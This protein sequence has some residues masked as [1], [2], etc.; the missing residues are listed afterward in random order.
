M[1]PRI[2]RLLKKGGYLAGKKNGKPVKLTHSKDGGIAVGAKH[3]LEG[4]IKGIVGTEKKPIEF[5]GEEIIITAPAVK[6]D[7][8]REFE[9]E[10]LTNRQIL[11]RI[12]ESGGGVSFADGGEIPK[13]IRCSGRTYNYGGETKTDYEIITSSCGCKHSLRK[14]GQ[15]FQYFD[16]QYDIDKA[17]KMIKSGRYIFDVK[18][19]PVYNV[20][21]PLFNKKYSDNL[22]PD[23]EVAQGLMIKLPGGQDFL[24]DGNHRMA[25]AHAKGMKKMKVYYIS[26]PQTIKEFSK[27]TLADGGPTSFS[28][29]VSAIAKNLKGQPVPAQYRKEYG[30]TYTVATA[31]EAATKIAGAMVRD[32]KFAEGGQAKVFT[33]TDQNKASIEKAFLRISKANNY[34]GVYE[35]TDEDGL[36]MEWGKYGY[37]ASESQQGEDYS[38]LLKARK[39]FNEEYDGS[40]VAFAEHSDKY[41]QIHILDYRQISN[42]EN[43]YEDVGRNKPEVL[44][45]INAAGFFNKKIDQKIAI[46]TKKKKAIQ[47]VIKKI[48]KEYGVQITE[49]EVQYFK[50]FEDRHKGMF[51]SEFKLRFKDQPFSEEKKFEN[52]EQLCN[53]LKSDKFIREFKDNGRQIADCTVWCDTNNFEIKWYKNEGVALL[54]FGPFSTANVNHSNFNEKYMELLNKFQVAYNEL[55]VNKAIE[56]FAEGGNVLGD[57]Y[58]K[59]LRDFKDIDSST[60]HI[61]PIYKDRPDELIKFVQEQ[62]TGLDTAKN[63]VHYPSAYQ[64]TVKLVGADLVHR[65]V[66]LMKPAEKNMLVKAWK[67]RIVPKQ[68]RNA[69]KQTMAE[70]GQVDD[71]NVLSVIFRNDFDFEVAKDF[72][73]SEKS[74]FQPFY[75]N[76]EFRS[77]DFQVKGQQDADTTEAALS[78]EL[79]NASITRYRFESFHEDN[80]KKGGFVPSHI[81]DRRDRSEYQRINNALNE[82]S[83]RESFF[84]ENAINYSPEERQRKFKWF[85]DERKKLFDQLD[86]ITGKHATKMADGG[87]INRNEIKADLALGGSLEHRHRDYKLLKA[88]VDYPEQNRDETEIRF[89]TGGTVKRYPDFSNELPTVINEQG[90]LFATEELTTPAVKNARQTWPQKEFHATKNVR[91]IQLSLKDVGN[92]PNITIRSSRDTYEFLK[93][94]WDN[95]LMNVQEQMYVLYLNRSNKVVGFQEL[96]KGGI[97]GTVADVELIVA[98]ASKALAKSVIIAHNH[99]SGNLKPSSADETLTRQTQD[100]LKLIRVALIDHIIMTS[101]EGYFSFMDEGL[102]GYEYGGQLSNINAAKIE[103]MAL[104]LQKKYLHG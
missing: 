44:K 16:T 77:I 90:A 29:K 46:E 94:I 69:V 18:E 91:E 101:N 63:K 40:L 47:S 66:A 36:T 84:Y 54:S 57:T 82:L 42:N 7:T 43:R 22:N 75:Y 27:K 21:H 97:D 67:G 71:T 26:N 70:G 81:K 51:S 9:G 74:S 23:F 99:P 14:G 52:A 3:G 28:D 65:A 93:Q 1:T 49:N 68:L 2:K 78:D 59:L 102:L 98:A 103:N 64:E 13:T 62:A 56:K 5:E 86:K 80:M 35:F 48:R 37:S 20:R 12:N 76:D 24:I 104:S 87:Q 8:K 34:Q 73:E 45:K 60:S 31:K 25:K 6:D 72:F 4:G 83:G 15:V 96:S 32:E 53:Y 38:E 50:Y 85:E 39:A 89:A 95:N 79:N 33:L 11:S 19:I 88:T 10:M 61:L 41:N 30:K 92:I 100:A 58:E 17:Y 55:V